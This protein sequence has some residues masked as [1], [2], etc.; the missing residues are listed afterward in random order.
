M[1]LTS[2]CSSVGFFLFS[3]LR[4]HQGTGRLPRE[5]P[6]MEVE[7]VPPKTNVSTVLTGDGDNAAHRSVSEGEEE[8]LGFS[9]WVGCR[10]L[11]TTISLRYGV[12]EGSPELAVG[13]LRGRLGRWW[14]DGGGGPWRARRRSRSWA[15]VA[16][17]GGSVVEGRGRTKKAGGGR[18]E[19]GPGPARNVCLRDMCGASS[20]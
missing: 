16:M 17:V 14:T 2:L 7:G 4:T 18:R 19:S 3:M 20:P 5:A 8:N 11:P 9:M 15:R 13:G 12:W 10:G 1:F 6:A